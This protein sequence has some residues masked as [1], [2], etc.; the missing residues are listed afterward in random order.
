M[1]TTEKR[2]FIKKDIYLIEIKN[3]LLNLLVDNYLKTLK[4]KHMQKDYHLLIINV[5][6]Q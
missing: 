6:I 1:K 3:Q 4:T 5:R 2:I